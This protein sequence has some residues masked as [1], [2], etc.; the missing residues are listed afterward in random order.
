M[1]ESIEAYANEIADARANA[2]AIDTAIIACLDFN[3]SKDETLSYVKS[4]FP[5]ASDSYIQERIAALFNK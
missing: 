5:D 4:K 3:Q 2:R 1:C